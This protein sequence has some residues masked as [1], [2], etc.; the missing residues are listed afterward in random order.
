MF[1]I[2]IWNF[3]FPGN[4]R[5]QVL[6]LRWGPF[7]P[8]KAL[9]QNSTFPGSVS[10]DD[11]P[12]RFNAF[13]KKL[14]LVQLA[15]L[16]LGLPLTISLHLLCQCNLCPNYLREPAFVCPIPVVLS[17]AIYPSGNACLAPGLFSNA[18]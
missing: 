16:R 4:T 12:A 11:Y 1:Y 17:G 9:V 14:C 10:S 5:L 2:Y 3:R 8:K 7:K 18:F 15:V 6:K 13:K